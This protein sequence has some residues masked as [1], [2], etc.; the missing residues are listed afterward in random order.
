M[1]ERIELLLI[2]IGLLVFLF[3]FQNYMDTFWAV[4]VLCVF[5]S[6]YMLYTYLFTR[7]QRRK[8]RKNPPVLNENFKPFVSILI[9]CHN[10][11][12]VIEDTVKN[13][14]AVDWEDYEMILIDDRSDDCT[15]E[16]LKKLSKEN[17]KVKYL[18]REKDAFPG[19][20]A[21]L[22][23]AMQIAKGE[24]I[25]VFDADARIKPD[26]I[27]KLLI[28]FEPP[29]VGAVQAQKSICNYKE[30]FLT[31]CQYNEYVVDTHIQV[32][33][34][35]VRGAVELRG[36]GEL[37]KRRALEDLGGW[38]ND[39]ITAALDMSTR[40]HISGWDI[41]FCPEAIVY[42][43]GVL[44]YPAL[45]KQ[46]RRWVE[47]SIRRYLEYMYGIF[48][49]RDMSLRVGADL[50]SYISIFLLPFWMVS[51]IAIQAF[52]IVKHGY[53]YNSILSSIIM[54]LCVGFLFGMCLFYSLRKYSDYSFFRRIF[55]AFATSFYMI[56]FWVPIVFAIILKI[57]FKPKTMDWGKT[58][59]GVSAQC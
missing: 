4:I 13:I 52:R 27:K 23:D 7:H 29:D 5:M 30:N 42:E 47:G 8:L 43:E 25:L 44:T 28:K 51:E 50:I 22:N 9:P 57:I 37:I 55:E 53:H 35:S 36:N 59:H 45:I 33:R 12:K 16:I 38:T 54:L 48:F 18:I 20:S 21:V 17:K 41:R 46:R 3:I 31:R 14:S 58:E 11:E 40:M 34:D 6:A 24:A 26:F 10:E 15:A 49:S 1:K 2:I 32:S 39:T 19:K 56:V